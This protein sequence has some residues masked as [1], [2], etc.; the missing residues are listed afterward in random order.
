[1][2]AA[3]S[4]NR[5]DWH[6]DKR[7]LCTSRRAG[8]VTATH[9]PQTDIT[10]PWTRRIGK[11]RQARSDVHYASPPSKLGLV[12][13]PQSGAAAAGYVRALMTLEHKE[14]TRHASI[15]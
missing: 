10:P 11:A 6:S 8:V 9:R 7:G 13:I 2:G 12:V 1:M 14:N 4:V 15:R 3:F 5:H